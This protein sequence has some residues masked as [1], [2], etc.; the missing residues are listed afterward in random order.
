VREVSTGTDFASRR[1]AGVPEPGVE[2]GVI[3]GERKEPGISSCR[4]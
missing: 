4:W 3:A 2:G 1:R